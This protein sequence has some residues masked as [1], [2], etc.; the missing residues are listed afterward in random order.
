M[1]LGGVVQEKI[2]KKV[3]S[4]N[5]ETYNI[6]LYIYIYRGATGGG[7]PYPAFQSL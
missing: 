7:A 6:H 3:G 2:D 1:M 4:P 5:T